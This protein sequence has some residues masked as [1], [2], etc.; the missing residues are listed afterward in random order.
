[1]SIILQ[2]ARSL[3]EANPELKFYAEGRTWVNFTRMDWDA[4]LKYRES[5]GAAILPYLA[6]VNLT[7]SSTLSV[8]LWVGPGNLANRESMLRVAKEHRLTGVPK[9][10]SNCDSTRQ[11]CEISSFNLL[12]L[13]NEV[14]PPEEIEPLI[15]VKWNDF[16]KRELP[17]IV[18]AVRQEEWLWDLPENAQ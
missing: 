13:S 18:E 4:R 2:Y 9:T 14:R 11:Y 10:L 7:R 15:L 16:L 8:G 1:M 5:S 6:F 3:V 12:N 17:C